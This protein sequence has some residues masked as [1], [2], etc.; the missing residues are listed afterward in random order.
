[1]SMDS[2]SSVVKNQQQQQRLQRLPQLHLD[3]DIAMMVITNQPLQVPI[4]PT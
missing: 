1:M 2:G 3:I 4:M